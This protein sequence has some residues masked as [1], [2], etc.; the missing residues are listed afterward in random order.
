MLRDANFNVENMLR[1]LNAPVFGIDLHWLPSAHGAI[2]IAQLVKRCHPKAKIVMGGLS[3]SYYCHELFQYPEVDFVIR[4][5]STEHPFLSLMDCIRENRDPSDIPNLVWRDE[6]GNIQENPLSHVPDDLSDV[7]IRHYDNTMRSV[8]RYRDLA[9]YMPFKRWLNYPITAVLT[10]RGCTQNCVICGGSAYAYR[11][12]CNRTSTVYRSPQAVVEDAKRISRFSTGPIFVLGDIRQPG[13]D[14]AQELLR[15]LQKEHVKNQFIMELFT[16][17]PR[18]FLQELG[19]ACPKFCLQIS[20]ESHDPD[21]RRASG[22]HYS[23]EDL[24]NTLTW[25]L[26]AGCGRLDLFF[27]IGMPKQT[28]ESAL[29]TIDY[30]EPLLKEL[31]KDGRFS[32]FTSPLAPFLDPG[33]LG[34]EQPDRYGYHSLWRTLEEHRT[35][36]LSPSWK[37]MLSYETDWMNRDQIVDV[38]YE[39]GLR[40]NRLKA[41]HNLI[42]S[43]TA[44]VTDKRIHTAMEMVHKL[45]DIVKH[46]GS[47]DHDAE[48]ATLKAT[49]DNVSMSTVCEKSELDLPVGIFR[50]RPLKALWT[51]MTDRA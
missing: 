26:D 47:A 1:K 32:C 23:S 33:S 27:M 51:W 41:K 46:R 19:K 16:P 6:Q 5:D 11:H 45:D 44:E 14:Y 15:L 50:L 37:Y 38:S 40:L 28:Q 48:L 35:A 2:A 30:C 29:A 22:K 42:S 20:P 43:D 12:L 10:C 39:A 25:A 36:L 9:S 34:F 24:E 49:V 13:D 3:A 21:V 7:M 18:D 31:G 8:I 4:G 17:A